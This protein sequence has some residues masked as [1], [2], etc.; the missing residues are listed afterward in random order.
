MGKP[1]A[2]RNVTL[3]V[4][5]FARIY[6][7]IRSTLLYRQFLH[8]W[9]YTVKVWK[10]L[11]K[12]R[13]T[14]IFYFITIPDPVICSCLLYFIK[15][16][17]IAPVFPTLA[18]ISNGHLD[19]SLDT[20]SH[21]LFDSSNRTLGCTQMSRTWQILAPRYRKESSQCGIALDPFTSPVGKLY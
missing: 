6:A 2:G 19:L 8:Y 12:I 13:G 3:V 20:I 4:V 18:S 7:V 14:D 15:S 5:N 21:W 10:Y 9:W 1:D 16:S 17:A 11:F